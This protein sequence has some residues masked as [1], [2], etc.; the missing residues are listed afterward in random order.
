[1]ILVR[2]EDKRELL[3]SLV[4]F[5]LLLS[6]VGCGAPKS[7]SEIV[8][9]FYLLASK[10]NYG[11]GS[12]HLS[13]DA[14]L[15]F[16]LFVGVAEGMKQFASEEFGSQVI[17]RV[18]ILSER[19]SGDQAEVRYILHYTDGTKGSADSDVLVKEK[20]QWKIGLSW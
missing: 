3:C 9:Q 5:A 10:G 18:E 16:G 15:M 17:R 2:E 8:T 11:S 14:K 7:P 20:G 19:V 6:I 1:M 4:V 12:K 13:S